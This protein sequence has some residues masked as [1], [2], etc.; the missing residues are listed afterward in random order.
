[1]KAIHL[2]PKEASL[3]RKWGK[4]RYVDA[5]WRYF[6]FLQEANN[7]ISTEAFLELGD[8]HPDAFELC[9]IRFENLELPKNARGQVDGII[10]RPM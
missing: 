6:R 4:E 5:L 9:E 3:K 8:K 2:S 7:P 10:R 1:M